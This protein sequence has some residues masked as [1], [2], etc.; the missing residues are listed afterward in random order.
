M[1]IDRVKSISIPISGGVL[2]IALVILA[3]AYFVEIT[4]IVESPYIGDISIAVQ[5]FLISISSLVGLIAGLV[6]IHN[7]ISDSNSNDDSGPADSFVVQGDV[8]FNLGDP[9]YTHSDSIESAVDSSD[10]E[11]E[12]RVENH[13]NGVSR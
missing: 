2:A 4:I 5:V 8:H 13:E 12:P 1:V 9:T 3:L 10:D 6:T 7:W 11:N